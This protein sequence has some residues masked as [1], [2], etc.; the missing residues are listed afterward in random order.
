MTEVYCD[1]PGCNWKGK[2]SELI[3]PLDDKFSYNQLCPNCL[4]P[5]SIV[6][7]DAMELYEYNKQER[8][9]INE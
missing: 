8:R 7:S 3:K 5:D 4:S 6:E 2:W 1:M 9:E